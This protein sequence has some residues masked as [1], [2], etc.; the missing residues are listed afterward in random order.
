MAGNTDEPDVAFVAFLRLYDRRGNVFT[1]WSPRG[2]E[3]ED[4]VGLSEVFEH[5]WLAL[6]ID[7]RDADGAAVGGG[8]FG[9]TAANQHCRQGNCEQGHEQAMA[10]GEESD[11]EVDGKGCV[12][13]WHLE[14][15]LA[16]RQ[17]AAGLGA[18]VDAATRKTV[19]PARLSMPATV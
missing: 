16:I 7:G 3:P 13:R 10:R 11:H 14:R 8:L 15:V 6:D 12:V 1:V 19:A 5:Q 17:L 9:T 4:G 2:P 18:A